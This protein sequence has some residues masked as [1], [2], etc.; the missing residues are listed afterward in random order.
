MRDTEAERNIIRKTEQKERDR[1]TAW[2]R[3]SER[4]RDRQTERIRDAE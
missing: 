4:K 1:E 2:K 3:G